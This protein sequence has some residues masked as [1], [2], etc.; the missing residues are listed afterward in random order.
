MSSLEKFISEEFKLLK[1]Y[2]REA[3]NILTIELCDYLY[4]SDAQYIDK[5]YEKAMKIFECIN[6]KEDELFIVANIYKEKDY[7]YK[8]K[9]NIERYLK[10]KKV[11]KSLNCISTDGKDVDS[12]VVDENEYI[13]HYYL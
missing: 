8:E 2:S 13:S 10:N 5:C 6:Y 3:D 12:S 9:I 4:T 7:N 11:L 1:L